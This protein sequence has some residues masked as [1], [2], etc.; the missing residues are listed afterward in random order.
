VGCRRGLDAVGQQGSLAAAGYPGRPGVVGAP[1]VRDR[2][3]GGEGEVAG[4]VVAQ[5]PDAR[6]EVA[7]LIEDRDDDL[8]LGWSRHQAGPAGG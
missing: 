3:H 1:V 5:P 4:Q 8:Y 7:F 2:D 6:A